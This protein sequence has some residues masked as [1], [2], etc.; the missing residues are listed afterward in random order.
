MKKNKKK[1]VDDRW[2]KKKEK[3]RQLT[4][5]QIEMRTKAIQPLLPINDKQKKYIE[6]LNTKKLVLA[7]GYAGTSK[8]Y[9]PTVMACDLFNQG[10]IDKIYITRPNISNSKSLGYFGGSLIEKMANWTLPILG[11][12][13]QRLERGQI[14][15]ALKHGQIVFVPMEVIKGMSF[16]SNSFT[17]CDEAEDLTIDEA[18][19]LT[20]RQGGGIMVLCGD[21]SQSELKERSGL[22]RL[23]QM[24]NKYQNLKKTVGFID[25]NDFGDIVRSDECQDWVKAW[26]QEELNA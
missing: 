8:T 18:K 1:V 19:K 25:F 22:Y 24:V 12:I 17:I 14:E 2:D 15:T 10:L 7:T 13:S 5:K 23:T 21:V 9:I 16:E 11:I 6:L 20:T 26:V 3:G 4:D